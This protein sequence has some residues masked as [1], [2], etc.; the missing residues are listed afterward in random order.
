MALLIGMG[1]VVEAQSRG[2]FSLPT[3]GSGRQVVQPINR[4]PVTPF[5]VAPAYPVAFTLLPAIL[6]SDGGIYANFGFGYEPVARAC[7][8]SRVIDGRGM[9]TS[10]R[11]PQQAPASVTSSAQNLPSVQAQRRAAARAGQT[12]CYARDSYGQLVVV[13]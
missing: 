10:Q 11:Y 8:R 7:G 3:H 13:R 2:V 9:R 1:Q 4:E 6:M 5:P 12:A